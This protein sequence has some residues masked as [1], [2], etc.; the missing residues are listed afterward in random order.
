MNIPHTIGRYEVRGI[1]GEGGMATVL[2]GW[3]PVLH[4]TLA[5]KLVDKTKLDLETKEE[6]LRRFKREAQ[7]AARLAHA[8]VVQVYEYGEEGDYCFIAME[9]VA[10]KPLT[11]YLSEGLK[12]EL[13]R[14]RDIIGQL[15]DALAYSHA[16][17]V[18]HRDIKPGN[19]L[20][21]REGNIKVTDFG[22]ARM[23]TSNVTQHGHM[24]G[25]P[26]LHV[27]A[28]NISARHPMVALTCSPPECCCTNC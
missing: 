21:T 20:V 2:E 7:A 6:T 17:G 3:D 4:R 5:V 1:L 10:G 16:Q 24:L 8:N 26:E 14:V 22:I 18:V 11:A 23:E 28:S 15:L 13:R 25:T 12:T 27:A 19:L 9:H